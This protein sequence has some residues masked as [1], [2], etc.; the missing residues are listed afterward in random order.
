M[1]QVLWGY[2][3]NRHIELGGL[4]RSLIQPWLGS[5]QVYRDGT[6]MIIWLIL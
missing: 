5:L 3:L 1:S 6:E 2:N 4:R